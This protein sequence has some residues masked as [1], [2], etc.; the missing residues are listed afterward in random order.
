MILINTVTG[1]VNVLSFMALLVTTSSPSSFLSALFLFA[2]SIFLEALSIYADKEKATSRII[3]V[4]MLLM[5]I[6]SI[7]GAC[8]S[9][10]G[11]AKFINVTLVHHN[12]NLRLMVSS[13]SNSISVI[14]STD[15][16]DLFLLCGYISL[17]APFVLAIR[18]FLVEKFREKNYNLNKG[19]LGK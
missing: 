19:L 1:I 5:F 6:I 4:T 16:T 2:S 10:A 15:I 11:L 18:E 14:P 8:F 13:Y 7:L 12:R 9:F 17:A 3:F